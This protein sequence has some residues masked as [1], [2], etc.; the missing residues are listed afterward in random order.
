MG[1]IRLDQRGHVLLATIDNP[2]HGLMDAGIV[3]SLAALV[4]RADSDDAVGAVVLTGTH[5]ERFVAHYDVGEL[6]AAARSGP[7]VGRRAAKGSLRVVAAL[8]RGRAVEAG[9][10]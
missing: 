7:S 5:P 6:L 2:P 1:E 9:V 10:E 8:R 4:Q 3:A